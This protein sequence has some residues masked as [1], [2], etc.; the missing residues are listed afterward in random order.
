MA[1]PRSCSPP[2]ELAAVAAAAPWAAGTHWWCSDVQP[3]AVM[4]PLQGLQLLPPPLPLLLMDIEALPS[5]ADP[6][7]VI[8]DKF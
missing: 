7:Q 8:L 6:L 5:M 2:A 3:A 1:T 4:R